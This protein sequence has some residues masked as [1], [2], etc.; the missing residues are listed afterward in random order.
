LSCFLQRQ[1]TGC[2]GLRVHLAAEITAALA[3]ALAVRVAD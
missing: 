2:S 3:R 1:L